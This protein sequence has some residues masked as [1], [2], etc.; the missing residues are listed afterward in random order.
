MNRRLTQFVET[1]GQIIQR[2]GTGGF[3]FVDPTLGNLL[4]RGRVEIMQLFAA[5]PQGDNEVGFD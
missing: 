3:V 2:A 4:E 5:A 1:R